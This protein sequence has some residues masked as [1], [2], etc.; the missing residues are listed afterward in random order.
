MLQEHSAPV[1]LRKFSAHVK[2]VSCWGNQFRSMAAAVQT[3]HAMCLVSVTQSY[4]IKSQKCVVS[5]SHLVYP[6]TAVG[7]H[8]TVDKKYAPSTSSNH[9]SNQALK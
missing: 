5:H 3:L 8:L 2:T 9:P 4:T 1:S 6:G 7:G